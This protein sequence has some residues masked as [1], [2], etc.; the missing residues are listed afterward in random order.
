MQISCLKAVSYFYPTTFMKIKQSS[1]QFNETDITLSDSGLQIIQK[2]N[3]SDVSY[4]PFS[5]AVFFVQ[6]AHAVL[7]DF[8]SIIKDIS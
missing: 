5:S 2:A 4:L 7:K 8:E 1:N 6:S 3:K